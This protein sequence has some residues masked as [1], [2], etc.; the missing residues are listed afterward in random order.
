LMI[1]P[2]GNPL[3]EAVGNDPISPLTSDGPVLEIAEPASTAKVVAVPSPTE[4]GPTAF[5]IP[6]IAMRARINA[7]AIVP[8]IA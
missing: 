4:V 2:G 6:V 5:A 1:V 7:A 8:L 3:I